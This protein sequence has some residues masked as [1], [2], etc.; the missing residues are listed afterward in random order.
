VQELKEVQE[1]NVS[2]L[3]VVFSLPRYIWNKSAVLEH[4]LGAPGEEVSVVQV[5]QRVAARSGRILGNPIRVLQGRE[6][7]FAQD[8]PHGK[9]PVT[10]RTGPQTQPC[11]RAQDRTG[12]DKI[13]QDRTGQDWIAQDR[14]G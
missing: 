2:R 11:T 7:I 10:C 5:K 3:P 4:K 1:L 14:T 12:Q 13:G 8:F 9:V 6:L